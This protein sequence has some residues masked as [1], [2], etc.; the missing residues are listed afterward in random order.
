L[1]LPFP[2][3]FLEERPGSGAPRALRSE[4]SRDCASLSLRE[5]ERA[6]RNPE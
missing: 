2:S 4:R 1:L 3:Q 5:R 6:R